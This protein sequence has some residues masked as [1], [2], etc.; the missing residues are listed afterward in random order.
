[1]K[2]VLAAF[3][4][5]KALVGAFS[6]ITNLR[7]ELFEAQVEDGWKAMTW[8]GSERATPPGRWRMGSSWW[9]QGTIGE[10]QLRNLR[11]GTGLLRRHSPWNIPHSNFILTFYASPN[12][13]IDVFRNACAIPDGDSVV[14]TGGKSTKT[15]VS[16]Y[17]RAGWVEDMPD[18]N[19][20]RATHGCAA[21]DINNEKVKL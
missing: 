19:L 6:V 13:T 12:S 15:K 17:N 7:M 4:Q 5:E 18:L 8:W 20:P 9:V 1:M 14:L 2:A 3:N 10:A 11:S 21:V 16:R